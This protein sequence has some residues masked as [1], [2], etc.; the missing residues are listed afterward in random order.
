MS[1]AQNPVDSDSDVSDVDRYLLSLKFHEPVKP[2]QETTTVS[3]KPLSRSRKSRK[4][5][6]KKRISKVI[7]N[8]KSKI[9][10]IDLVGNDT[11]SGSS[12]FLPTKSIHENIINNISKSKRK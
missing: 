12:V 5:N 2:L 3:H 1:H 7:N 6:R 10:I 8:A 4:K 9:P 11:L